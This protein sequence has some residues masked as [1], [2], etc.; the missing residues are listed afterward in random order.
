MTATSNQ[1]GNFKTKSPNEP[2]PH[3]IQLQKNMLRIKA[4]SEVLLVIDV[5]ELEILELTL[6]VETVSFVL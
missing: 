5:S 2:P 1:T 3:N 4:P 6:W